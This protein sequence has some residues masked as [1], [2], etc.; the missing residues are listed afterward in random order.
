MGLKRKEEGRKEGRD[1]GGSDSKKE[2]PKKLVLSRN[3]QLPTCTNKECIISDRAFIMYCR[4]FNP[5]S[6][7]RLVIGKVGAI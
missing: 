7:S 5:I 3:R 6:L 4:G 2:N 1:E